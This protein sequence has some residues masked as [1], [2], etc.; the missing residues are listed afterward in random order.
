L[1][2]KSGIRQ[3][4]LHKRDALVTETRRS[5]DLLIIKKFLSLPE[6]GRSP[7]ILFFASFRSEVS[8]SLLIE[9]A[10]RSGKTVVLPSVDTANKELRLYEIRDLSEL[11][12]GYMGIPEPSVHAQ[13]ERDINDVTLV[14]LPGAAFDAAGNRLGYGGGYYDKLLSR[15]RRKIPLI[16]LAYE[17]Q[18]ADSLPAEPHDIKVH[19]IVTDERVIRCRSMA[20]TPAK[21]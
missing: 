8:T 13:R 17:E 5:K 19:V 4:A 18:M 6:F 3:Q 14:V 9:E 15:L 21:H 1:D 2:E 12:A 7:V 11:S 20:K 10:L 16:A